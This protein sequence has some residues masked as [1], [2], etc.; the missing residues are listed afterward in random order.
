M[1]R[2]DPKPRPLREWAN[3]GSVNPVGCSPK[4]E[5]DLSLLARN[6]HR[7]RFKA[8]ARRL[9]ER[10]RIPPGSPRK[11]LE[12]QRSQGFFF[13]HRLRKEVKKVAF[14]HKL[15]AFIVEMK[16]SRI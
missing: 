6:E 3:E 8:P 11:I 7:R 16:E 9:S 14:L 2:A 4:G 12:N 15:T 5:S 10:N 1:K 13:L